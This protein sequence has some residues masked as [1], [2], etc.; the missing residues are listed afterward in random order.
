M[1]RYVSP[2]FAMFRY[3]SL[4]FAMLL[5]CFV[6]L[7][8]VSLCCVM[9]HYVALCFA[10][11][12]YVSLCCVM[13]RY[14]ASCLTMLRS[15]SLCCVMSHYV[16]LCFA[17]L[18]LCCSATNTL[19][20]GD[21]FRHHPT[22]ANIV[23]QFQIDPTFHPT[24]FH[25]MLGDMSHMVAWG[26]KATPGAIKASCVM[27]RSKQLYLINHHSSQEHAIYG[28]S[29]LLLAFRSPTTCHLSNLRSINLI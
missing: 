15:V 27:L 17:M 8:Y 13:F 21:C 12:R 23:D 20:N 11:L 10:M 1:F 3:A 19:N 2:C 5:L 9:S 14:V 26:D 29:C 24:S 6:M 7:R 16:A 4:C 22:A 28:P 25:T 18:R